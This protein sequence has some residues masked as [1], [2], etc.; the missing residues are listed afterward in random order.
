MLD[1]LDTALQTLLLDELP[2]VVERIEADGFDITF[3]VPNRENTA[4]LTRPTLNVFLYNVQENRELRPAPWETVRVNGALEDRRPP[5]RLECH[6]L[7]TAWS[8][9]VEDEHRLLT[10]AARVFF[11]HMRLP[12]S[13]I[14][15]SLPEEFE[16]RMMVA[17]PGPVKDIIDIWSVLDNDLKPSVRVTVTVPL[18]LDVTRDAPVITER[19]LEF[20]DPAP[21]VQVERRVDVTGLVSRGDAPVAG[22]RVRMDRSTALTRLDGTFELSGV[23]GSIKH[24]LVALHGDV[25]R[26]VAEHAP[27]E[28]AAGDVLLLD[29]EREANEEAEADAEGES[30]AGEGPEG[31]EG[32]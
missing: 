6:Y 17:Q 26:V 9:E 1:D 21:I 10:G 13:V 15:G 22:A 3:D 31:R 19:R 5:V 23:R 27:G 29:L 7:V 14:E 12:D 2:T 11:R 4:R 30:A 18:E 24:A 28:L 32:D 8:N 16:L 25:H 20:A